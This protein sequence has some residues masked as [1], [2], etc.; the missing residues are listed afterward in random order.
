MRMKGVC[1]KDISQRRIFPNRSCLPIYFQAKRPQD[2][3]NHCLSAREYRVGVDM[4]SLI[5]VEMVKVI[6]MV[7][8]R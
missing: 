8:V 7:T 4:V 1:T 2:I 6:N 3:V 5:T